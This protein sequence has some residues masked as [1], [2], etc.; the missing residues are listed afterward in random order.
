MSQLLDTPPAH[1]PLLSALGGLTGIQT[2]INENLDLWD[3]NRVVPLF[4]FDGQSITGQEEVGLKRRQAATKKTDE[5]WTLYQQSQ[6][7]EAVTTFGSNAGTQRR[8]E[9]IICLIFFESWALAN[10]LGP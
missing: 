10:L 6:A 7:E 5:A 8:Q 2:H 3:K 9:C 1:E 4:V